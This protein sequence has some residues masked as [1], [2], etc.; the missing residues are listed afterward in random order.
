MLRRHTGCSCRYLS[1]FCLAIY[2][3]FADCVAGSNLSD[4][5]LDAV[6]FF[7]VWYEDDVTLDS[8][9][10]VSTSTHFIDCDINFFS[11]LHW[12]G[13]EIRFRKPS[14]CCFWSRCCACVYFHRHRIVAFHLLSF[15]PRRLRLYVSRAVLI[16]GLY[17]L[18]FEKTEDETPTAHIS[19]RYNHRCGDQTPCPAV[20]TRF[21][22][23]T[24][25]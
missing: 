19:T 12:L 22:K 2:Y 5:D 6:S 25:S 24:T 9:H 8:G 14:L 4:S 1:I 11:D 3:Y 13:H 7:G 18:L 17:I 21:M 15:S 20:T 23:A 10:S 16:T